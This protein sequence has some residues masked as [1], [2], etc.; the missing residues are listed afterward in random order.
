[1]IVTSHYKLHN[2][3]RNVAKI[4][5][6][7]MSNNQRRV[8]ICCNKI[9]TMSRRRV[10][11]TLPH[12]AKLED[13]A[14]RLKLMGETIVDSMIITKILMT[15]ACR[16]STFCQCLESAPTGKRT[17]KK[18]KATNRDTLCERT[19]METFSHLGPSGENQ[20]VAEAMHRRECQS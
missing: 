16:L 1:M 12:I 6:K 20:S 3:C 13:I 7:S 17:L 10:Q 5:L 2:N 15:L 9:G 4:N 18:L 19:K 14:H 8:Y 11:M